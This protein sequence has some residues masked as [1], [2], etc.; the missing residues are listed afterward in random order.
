MDSSRGQRKYFE[1]KGLEKTFEDKWKIRS[2]GNNG[3]VSS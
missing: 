1:I 2:T 3:K